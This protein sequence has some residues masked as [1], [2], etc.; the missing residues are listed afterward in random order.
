MIHF[1]S[2]AARDRYEL[3]LLREENTRLSLETAK[4]RK[5]K[6]IVHAWD[7]EKDVRWWSKAFE[8][9]KPPEDQDVN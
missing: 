4:L 1:P 9:L 6:D 2:K 7:D 8:L 3:S 5:C